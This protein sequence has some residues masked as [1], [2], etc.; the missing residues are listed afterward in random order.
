MKLKHYMTIGAVLALVV[1]FWSLFRGK[2][3][4]A[5]ETPAQPEEAP[6]MENASSRPEAEPPAAS[7]PVPRASASSAS[8]PNQPAQQDAT[9]AYEQAALAE[10][11]TPIEF[12][13][14]VVDE[15]TNA[16]AGANVRF[17]WTDIT[18]ENASTARTISDETGL[19]SLRGKHGRSL[20]VWVNKAGYYAAQGGQKTFLY[21]LAS[22]KF[23]PDS[24]SPVIFFL[25][26]KGQLEALRVVNR[27]Y[28]IPRDGTPVRI[29]LETGKS[30]TGDSGGDLTVRCWT[31]DAGKRRGE[32]YDWRCQVDIPGGG[33]VISDRELDF[34]APENGYVA[35]TE[36]TMPAD[37]P[38]WKND[39]DLKFFYRLRDGRYGRMAFSMIAGGDHFCLVD[40]FLNPSG[41]RNLESDPQR[42]VQSA[43]Q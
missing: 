25:K 21:T 31:E 23:A 40:S 29:D 19:F 41:S 13:G 6:A 8:V 3:E 43:S 9:K 42:A 34:V 17:S 33:L 39:V 38:D 7:S 20:T 18:N 16:V 14:K 27:S 12:Y 1:L 36:I 28:K 2:H 37:R 30:V 22:E 32:K 11:Q 15:N 35:S 10:W 5:R 4:Q 26:K 24:T